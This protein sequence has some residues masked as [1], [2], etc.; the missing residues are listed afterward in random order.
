[1]YADRLV[2]KANVQ[3]VARESC[4]IPAEKIRLHR[5]RSLIIALLIL[6]A[7]AI[8]GLGDASGF[9][10]GDFLAEWPLGITDAP[11]AL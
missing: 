8:H 10:W 4:S 2:L 5:V 3:A 11:F 9:L 6:D 7:L 1:M